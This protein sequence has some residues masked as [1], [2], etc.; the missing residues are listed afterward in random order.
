VN[1][2]VATERRLS[3]I[4][5]RDVATERRLSHIVNRDMATERRLS[6]IL[7]RDVAT[8]RRLSPSSVHYYQGCH[9]LY[10]NSEKKRNLRPIDCVLNPK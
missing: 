8:E 5:N 4:M 9:Y 10:M 6:H 7:N 1:R 3:H 2:D